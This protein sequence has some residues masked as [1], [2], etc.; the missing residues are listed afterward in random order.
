M[1]KRNEG[2]EFCSFFPRDIN[3]LEA[4]ELEIS[5]MFAFRANKYFISLIGYSLIPGGIIC[6]Q[7]QVGTMENFIHTGQ[8]ANKELE[9][10]Y[11]I[12]VQTLIIRDLAVAVSFIHSMGFANLKLRPNTILLHCDSK[13]LVYP[14]ISDFSEFYIPEGKIKILTKET[15]DIYDMPYMAPEVF[16]PPE[17]KKTLEFLQKIDIYA[18]AIIVYEV[19]SRRKP[20]KDMNKDEIVKGVL[21]GYRPELEDILS[22]YERYEKQMEQTRL[23]GL[24]AVKLGQGFSRGSWWLYEEE[25]RK[26]AEQNKDKQEDD[27]FF[28]RDV[29]VRDTTVSKVVKLLE[30]CWKGHAS[31]RLSADSIVQRTQKY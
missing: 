10:P 8:V 9:I 12:Q 20:W 30:D 27:L 11:T 3:L 7:M 19:F 14:V 24:L 13:D 4:F 25:E 1:I 31:E 2:I 23:D 29:C 16:Q 17:S 6:K 21:A 22:R 5:L 26:K 28:E 15:V 18:Y